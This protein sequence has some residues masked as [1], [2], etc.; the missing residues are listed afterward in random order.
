MT[1]PYLNVQFA[2]QTFNL[3]TKLVRFT[4]TPALCIRQV[5]NKHISTPPPH[6][7][8]FHFACNRSG[9]AY[10]SLM[11]TMGHSQQRRY[12]VQCRQTEP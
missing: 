1:W 10:Q 9:I 12:Y 7:D 5:Q 11:S 6:L 8:T 3:H 4:H 2:K